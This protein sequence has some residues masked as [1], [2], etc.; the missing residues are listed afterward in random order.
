MREASR[1]RSSTRGQMQKL[2]AGKFHRGP[3]FSHTIHSIT[4]SARASRLGGIS[5]PSALAVL[6]LMTSSYFVGA[7][8]GKSAGFSPLRMRSI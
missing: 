2:S 5:R 7:W 1:Q 4:W 3:S 6:R 8:T